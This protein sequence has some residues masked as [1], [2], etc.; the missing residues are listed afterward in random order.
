M[1]SLS[2][3]ALWFARSGMPPTSD[4]SRT[5]AERLSGS[6]PQTEIVIV[7]DW[8]EAAR[9]LAHA[10]HDARDWD[11]REE[12]REALW[13]QATEFVLEAELLERLAQV[14]NAAAAPV[15]AAAQAAAMRLVIADAR[16][17][18]EAVAAAQ[19]A[20]QHAALA[21][22]TT[23]PPGHPFRGRFAVFA[24]GRW[25]LAAIGNRIHVF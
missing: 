20:L 8:V 7:A 6:A 12:E 10:E 4:E 14:R 9:I 24:A 15:R 16:F 13:E 19:V 5:L 3:G 17:V 2:D 18:D 11:A 22:L 21:T 23:A 1:D 25:P